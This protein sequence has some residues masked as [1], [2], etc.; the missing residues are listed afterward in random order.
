[1]PAFK[2]AGA[3]LNTVVSAGGVSALHF[4]KKYGFREA[5]TDSDFLFSNDAIDTIVVATRHNI[6]AVQV[7]MALESK[8]HVFCEK[9]LC[10]TIDELS[11]IKDK[12]MS[13]PS[14]I[15]MVGFNRRFAPQIRK[16]KSLLSTVHEPKAITIT[17]NSGKIPAGHWTQDAAV[18]GGRMIGEGCH[19]LDLARYLVGSKILNYQVQPSVGILPLRFVTINSLLTLRSKMVHLHV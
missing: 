4:G 1:M 7:L 6:H 12:S 14:K 13:I 10:L 19:F 5:S 9:P 11:E 17:V 8:K 16:M 18:G 15:L 3:E 2:A